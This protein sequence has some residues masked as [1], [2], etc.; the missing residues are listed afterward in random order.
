MSR[1]LILAIV[2][3]C[4]LPARSAAQPRFEP[5]P[6]DTIVTSGQHVV[7]AAPDLAFVTLVAESRAQVPREAQR[8]T[9]TTMA[10]VQQR[11]KALGIADEALQ[12]RSVDL[13]PE[14]DYTDGKQR[15]RG[16]LARNVV[17]VRV[18]DLAR[19]SEVIDAA[20]GA[21][22]SR[23]DGLRFDLKRREEIERQ[24]L[25][26]AVEDALQRARA[27]ASGAGRQMGA[28]L[29]IEDARAPVAPDPRPVFATRMAMEAAVPQAATPVQAGELEVT[30]R[31]TVVVR[32]Q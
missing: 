31:V 4:L 8:L 19:V 32:L 29:R 25:A 9:A 22:A 2:A 12:T 14:Y 13:Q 23:V 3:T 5:P 6:G 15:L 16:Y 28:V 30:A 26:R 27:M 1:P 17:E 20:V 10:A 7:R 24:A 11:V 18:E 21:G